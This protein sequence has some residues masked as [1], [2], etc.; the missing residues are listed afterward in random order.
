MII[1]TDDYIVDSS[2]LN[3]TRLKGTLRLPSPLSYEDLFI[4]IKSG[5]QAVS[6]VYV[7]DLCELQFLNSSGITALARLII[8]A[9]KEDKRIKL[10]ISDDIPWQNRSLKSLKNLWEKLSIVSS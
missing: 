2:E 7:I 9:R 8:L 4:D 3:L 6:D 1:K 10:L 5:I